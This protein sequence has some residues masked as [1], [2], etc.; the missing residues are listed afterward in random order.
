MLVEGRLHIAGV[1]QHNHVDAAAECVA[2]GVLACTGTLPPCATF[3]GEAGAGHGLATCSPGQ[4]DQRG[5][6]CGLIVE[7]RHRVECLVDPSELRER[8]RQARWP[9]PP[10]PRAHD[11]GGR[12]APACQRADRPQHIVPRVG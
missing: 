5:A 2:L 6:T 1:P 7:G 11:T 8:R 9:I 4:L 10:L 12:Y 3:A